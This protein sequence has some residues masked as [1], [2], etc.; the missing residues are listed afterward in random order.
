MKILYHAKLYINR[1]TSLASSVLRMILTMG[2]SSWM[3]ESIGYKF[4]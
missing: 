4:Y 2:W 3:P 1:L